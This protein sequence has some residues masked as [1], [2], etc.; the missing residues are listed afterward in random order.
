MPE[1]FP[2]KPS[3]VAPGTKFGVDQPLE[4]EATAI[5]AEAGFNENGTNTAEDEAER[6]AWQE[7]SY[8]GESEDAPAEVGESETPEV[9]MNNPAEV[10]EHRPIESSDDNAADKTG[11]EDQ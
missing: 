5:L 3:N 10:G 7:M 9:D 1:K 8:E 11:T 4:D 2:S 6:K